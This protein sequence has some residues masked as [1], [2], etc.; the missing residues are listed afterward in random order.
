[1]ML[2]KAMLYFI[3]IAVGLLALLFPVILD[4]YMRENMKVG[5][6]NHGMTFI[7]TICLF[8]DHGADYVSS[9]YFDYFVDDIC[10]GK[11]QEKEG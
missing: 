11:Q 5:A 7:E 6:L 4:V 10:G 9:Q 2:M 3:A 1:M 8:G